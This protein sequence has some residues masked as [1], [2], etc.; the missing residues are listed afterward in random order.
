MKRQLIS[1]VV[2]IVLG[3]GSAYGVDAVGSAF[4]GLTTAQAI[5]QGKGTFGFSVGLADATSFTGSFKY[6]LS[7]YT[8]GR[9]KLGLLDTD[10]S[11]AKLVLGADFTWQ[12]W[13]ATPVGDKPFDLSLG[14][15]FEYSDLEG[16][17]VLQVGAQAIASYPI[18][19]NEGKSTIIPY[20]RIN[21]RVESISLDLPAGA[22]GDDSESNLE[23]GLNGGLMW[24]M[25]PVWGLYGEFQID[26][27][28]GVFF[29]IDMNVM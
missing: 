22:R 4:G 6:G 1:L 12:F 10:Y 24:Q 9:I 17:S 16:V 11:D 23:M 21:A 3:A 15:F 2:L 14:G 25:T 27:N 18:V 20:G 5:G 13:S 29:G 26:G 19:F 7:K 8:D 28:D